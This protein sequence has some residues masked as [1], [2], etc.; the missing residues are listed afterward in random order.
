MQENDMDYSSEIELKYTEP[1]NHDKLM[2]FSDSTQNTDYLDL[3]Q[4]IFF[5]SQKRIRSKGECRSAYFLKKDN[6]NMKNDYSVSNQNFYIS[7]NPNKHSSEAKV[8]ISRD[9]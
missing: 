5:E 1:Y 6:I 2:K 7:K 4:K 9:F 8:N 3:N